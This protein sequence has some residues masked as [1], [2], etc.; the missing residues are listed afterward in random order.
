MCIKIGRMRIRLK[1]AGAALLWATCLCNW[2]SQG[3]T[4]EHDSSRTQQPTSYSRSTVRT[5]TQDDGLAVIA[6]ALDPKVRRY[7]GRDCSHWCMRFTN[8]PAFPTPTQ[9]PP[10]F[11]TGSTVLSES[12]GR[13]RVIWSC[14]AGTWALWCGRQGTSSSAFSARGREWMITKRPTGP[15]AD[16]PASTATSNNNVRERLPGTR[17]SARR[18]RL[19]R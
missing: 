14:G 9:I 17:C 3:Q 10:I 4:R 11:T 7:S 19:V 8:E 6:A 2:P 18:M 5:L 13:N 16:A 12:S 1:A 15:V